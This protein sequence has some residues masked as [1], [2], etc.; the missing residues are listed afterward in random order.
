MDLKLSSSKINTNYKCKTLGPVTNNIDDYLKIRLKKI[1][2]PLSKL[3]PSMLSMNKNIKAFLFVN[4]KSI[5]KQPH[6][7]I[8]IGKQ[9]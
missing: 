9:G 3:L 2:D 6:P 1:Q 4:S 8:S 5:L 7:V